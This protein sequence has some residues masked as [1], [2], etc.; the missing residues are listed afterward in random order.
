MQSKDH[1]DQQKREANRRRGP[2]FSF[3]GGSTP[4][5]GFTIKRGVGVGGF[6]EVYYATS[7]AGKE[8]ALKCIQ[9]N[10]DIELRG[11]RQCLNL[12]HPNLVS[13][14]DIKYDEDDQAWVVM[15]YVGGES[16]Q[17]VIERNPNGMPI[18]QV[19]DWFGGISAGVA[20]LHD[21]G[22]V[23]RDLKP[24]NIFRDGAIVKIGD[25]GLSKFISC[26]RRSGQTQ[27]VGT[28]HYMA[29]E[30][31]QGR[32][33][34][35]IDVYALGIMLY[36]M[37][38]GRVPYDGE[39]SQEIIMKH[40]TAQPDMSKV[41]Q[42]YH[43]VI[44]NALA[45]DPAARNGSVHEMRAAVLGGADA[46]AS[47]TYFASSQPAD[48]RYSPEENSIQVD[49]LDDGIVT[50]E[51]AY[52]IPEEPIARAVREAWG[53]LTEGWRHS[54]FGSTLKVVI[55]VVG[56]IFMLR[57]A[58]VMLPYLITLLIAYAVYAVIRHVI[59]SSSMEHH[60]AKM[61]QGGYNVRQARRQRRESRKQRK[62]NMR[63]V[64]ASQA[65]NA[66]WVPEEP[67]MAEPVKAKR[68]VARR[69]RKAV[70]K[71]KKPNKSILHTKF[72]RAELAQ[73][74]KRTPM[75]E[76]TG[77]YLTAGIVAAVVNLVMLFVSLNANDMSMSYG[78]ATQYVWMTIVSIMGAWG[79]LTVS[80]MWENNNGSTFR[81]RLT[82]LF[83]G[84]IVGAAAVGLTQFIG[85]QPQYL[86]EPIEGLLLDSA[87][88]GFYTSRGTP[89]LP[90]YMA[91]FGLLFMVVRW[92]RQADPIRGTRM[93]IW[94]TAACVLGALITQAF[95]PMPGGFLIPA[96][97]AVAVQSAAPFMDK[98]QRREVCQ[99]GEAAEAGA[100]A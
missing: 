22:I 56:I 88:N 71:I 31:G 14:Y 57:S 79:I 92:W 54:G 10:L 46:S 23:H 37:L 36:E 60:K 97:V 59:L 53:E 12:K 50:A 100:V 11:V 69:Q 83:V 49:G 67:V 64:A 13:L 68:R 15:E 3:A 9:R 73:K 39:S 65:L 41:A 43:D 35:E 86:P 24:G 32:Y 66:R 44:V 5:E 62:A 8:V 63:A 27:S 2:R 19:K 21:C 89:Q 85:F 72:M 99:K 29:P 33:G 75:T 45:K 55:P 47:P 96:S 30:I 7:D 51:M 25:Y 28:F 6:G 82:L 58:P 40:L 90:A 16:L 18:D 87:P 26:S 91:F 81:R 70:V 52:E 4:L 38:T 95:F 94:A 74:N 42:P 78:W 20:H 84:G 98:K 93:G 76:L 48:I 34:K 17:A 77:S 61:Q 1:S 80:K